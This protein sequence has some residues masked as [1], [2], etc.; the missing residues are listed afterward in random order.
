MY[1]MFAPQGWQCP[2]CGRVYSPSTTMCL[3]CGRSDITYTSTGTELKTP[4]VT[5]TATQTTKDGGLYGTD[6]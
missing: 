6:H 5:T 4:A 2:I 3:F 1:E